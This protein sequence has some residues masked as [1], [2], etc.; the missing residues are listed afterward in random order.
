VVREMDA[1]V[2]PVLLRQFDM[3]WALLSQHLEHL[4]DAEC[5]WRPASRGLHVHQAAD[6]SW[7]A[8]WPEHEG[9]SLGPP[10]IAWLTWHIHFWWS[11]AYDW[12]FGAGTMGRQDVTWP[13]SAE[14]VRETLAAHHRRWRERLDPTGATGAPVPPEARWPFHDRPFEDVVAWLNLELMKNAAEI[15]I[16]R[17]LYAVRLPQPIYKEPE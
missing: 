4:D 16:T 3:A 9:Y 6:G 5:L 11:M 15:G 2:G 7:Q 12:H 17:F 10:S 8:D 1:T 13:G 14:R